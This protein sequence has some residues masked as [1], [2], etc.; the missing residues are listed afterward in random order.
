MLFLA[1]LYLAFS[2]L[3]VLPA[4]TYIAWK[5]A[6]L[7]TEWGY[8][9]ALPGL[10][11]A[12]F[13]TAEHK[14][15]K[16]AALLAIVGGLL[17]LTP[18][19]RAI[20]HRPSIMH[21]MH[22]THA[23]RVE[24]AHYTYS[25]GL[26]LDLYKPHSADGASPVVVVIHGGSWRGGDQTQLAKLNSH[27][28]NEGYAVAAITY[29]LAPA[30]K[31]PAAYDD[32]RAAIAFLKARAGEFG[33]DASR[34]VLL[35]RSA[36]GQL[37]LLTAYTARDPAIKG[38]ISFYG[39]T[40]LRWGWEHPAAPL[41]IDSRGVLEDYIGGTPAQAGAAYDTA[42][43][44]DHVQTATPTLLIHGGRDELV[45]DEHSRMLYERLMAAGKSVRYV[46][47]PWATHG[48]DFA[49]N[50]PCGQVS[51]RAVLEFLRSVNGPR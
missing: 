1:V 16:I 19:A 43:P 24:P 9:F 21:L 3:A 22:G 30:H 48:C 41:V 20:P 40:D 6:I 47:L 18:L 34:I 50:G 8:W 11:A 31:F 51:T 38:A 39:V 25:P 26:A 35:G 29:R 44:I 28:A 42:S 14:L 15:L 4:P 13:I 12:A 37:A 5:L 45:F 17:L 23:H 2:L 33:I 46:E 7:A 32:V 10:I 27:L 36:G 49:F